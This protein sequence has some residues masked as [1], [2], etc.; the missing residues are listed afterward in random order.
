MTMMI[1]EVSKMA[2]KLELL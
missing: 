2:T 1:E